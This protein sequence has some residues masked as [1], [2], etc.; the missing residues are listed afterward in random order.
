M[1]SGQVAVE[2]SGTKTQEIYDEVFSKMVKDAQPIPGFRRAKGGK[3][4]L[5]LWKL[6]IPVALAIT[7]ARSF[8]SNCSH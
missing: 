3:S 7:S 6:K 8:V 5:K 1:A 4:L 2:V